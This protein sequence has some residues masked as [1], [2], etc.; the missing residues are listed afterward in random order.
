MPPFNNAASAPSVHDARLRR[1][2]GRTALAALAT[3]AGLALVLALLGGVRRVEAR[4]ASPNAADEP[5]MRHMLMTPKRAVAAG[6]SARAADVAATLRAAI[7][8]YRD[9]TAAVADGF[10]MFAPQVKNQKVY[11]FTRGLNAVSEAF[12]FDPAEPTSLLYVEDAGGAFRLVGAMYTAPKRFDLEQ[13]DAR[14]P[15]SIARWHKHVNWC[16]PAVGDGQRWLERTDG[17]PVFGPKSPIATK[18]ACDAVGGR[19]LAS[20]LGWMV[21][22]NVMTSDDPAVIWGDDHA[23][24]GDHE[25]GTMMNMDHSH[26]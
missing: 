25:S 26:M 8:K 12:R 13:L 14:V 19:F 9:T 15:L 21:H 1:S 16:V 4:D 2:S 6:D 11:H 7:E 5:E 24:G 22:A 23:H 17:H 3:L 20:P 10:H 18:E